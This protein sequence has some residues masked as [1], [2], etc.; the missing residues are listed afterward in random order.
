MSIMWFIQVEDSL[1][2]C[3]SNEFKLVDV[4]VNFALAHNL[5]TIL[6]VNMSRR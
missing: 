5:A 2:I 6:R 3:L 1:N 4:I